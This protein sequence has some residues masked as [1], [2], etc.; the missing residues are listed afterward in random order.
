MDAGD[1]AT[2]SGHADYFEF[3]SLSQP[4]KGPHSGRQFKVL[5]VK[6]ADLGGEHR[7]CY[8]LSSA[9]ASDRNWKQGVAQSM[10]VARVKSKS[11]AS[12]SSY[13]HQ[14]KVGIPSISAA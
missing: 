5:R 2:L 10:N 11:C 6:S 4:L 12:S 7:K 1:G 3:Y 9:N 13:P 8:S 14:T